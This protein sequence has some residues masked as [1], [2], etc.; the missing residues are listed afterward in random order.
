[1]AESGV[2]ER[3]PT[4]QGDEPRDQMVAR[5]VE[6]QMRGEVVGREVLESGVGGQLP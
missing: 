2:V 1:M 6:V 4:E 3:K 5:A